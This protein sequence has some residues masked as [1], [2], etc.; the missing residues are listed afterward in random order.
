MEFLCMIHC[1]KLTRFAVLK[2]ASC[3]FAQ[4]EIVIIETPAAAGRRRKPA[5][6]RHSWQSRHC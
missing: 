2:G 3:W 4:Q 5:I 6:M 1:N